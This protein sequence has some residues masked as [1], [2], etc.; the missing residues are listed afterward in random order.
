M[1][2]NQVII[3]SSS[4]SLLPGADSIFHSSPPFLSGFRSDSRFAKEREPTRTSPERRLWGTAQ[5]L[6]SQYS[7][8]Y[9][10]D[11][12]YPVIALSSRQHV[13]PPGA[14]AGHGR[15]SHAI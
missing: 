1:Q 6:Y 12:P 7:G 2:F 5:R 9:R 3:N 13:P 10:L 14:V 15:P 11:F 4:A 8:H